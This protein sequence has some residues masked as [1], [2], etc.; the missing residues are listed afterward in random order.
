MH[1]LL[2]LSLLL[3]ASSAGTVTVDPADGAA[4]LAALRKAEPGDS[5][6]V[7]GAQGNLGI[8]YGIGPDGPWIV[9]VLTGSSAE[10]AGLKP[11]DRLLS[12]NGT[13]MEA[14]TLQEMRP[15]MGNARGQK[16]S[17][18]ILRDGQRRVIETER[19]DQT[20]SIS[21]DMD[22]ARAV[23]DSGVF[24]CRDVVRWIKP[25]AKRGDPEAMYRMARV[26]NE[27]CGEEK[28]PSEA[29]AWAK[30]AAGAGY[31]EAMTLAAALLKQK[32]ISG[33]PP[34]DFWA[35]K[36]C[37]AKQPLGCRLF[38][39]FETAAAL[40]DGDSAYELA[41]K[42][43]PSARPRWLK[44]AALLGNES[45]RKAFSAEFSTASCQGQGVSE[46]LA[47]LRAQARAG[48]GDAA[49]L[50]GWM[51]AAGDCVAKDHAEAL[52]WLLPQ[53]G[54]G[55]TAAMTGAGWLYVNGEGMERDPAKAVEWF[56]K[57][58]GRHDAAAQNNLALMYLY[59]EGTDKNEPEAMKWLRL[60]GF[61]NEYKSECDPYA[62]VRS[63]VALYNLAL[64]FEHGI[65]VEKSSEKAA[66][67]YKRAAGS[68]LWSQ[69]RVGEFRLSGGGGYALG[70]DDRAAAE[71]FRAAAKA[72]DPVAQY[73]MGEL[74]EQGRGVL[75]DARQAAVWYKR[76]AAFKGDPR[77]PRL[78]PYFAMRL[79]VRRL[80]PDS[81]AE[82]ELTA[83]KSRAARKAEEMR[84]ADAPASAQS[85]AV[86]IPRYKLPERPS[87]FAVVVGVERYAHL[88]RAD[89][90]ERDAQAVRDHLVALGYPPRNVA[91]LKGSDASRASIAKNLETWLPMNV[92]EDS[93]VFFYF[94]G[95]G[96]P[97]PRSGK[98]FLVP[99]DGDA[100]FLDDTAYPLTRV[101]EK[102]GALKARKVLVALDACFS[103][104]GERSALA[105]G[106][107]P[108]VVAAPPAQLP[109]KLAVLS[110]SLA[111]E[112]SGTDDE[113]G[114][115]LFTYYL[116]KGINGEAAAA[117]GSV[118]LQGLHG[119][120]LPI[121][122][123]EARR[124]NRLQTP[125]LEG[126]S[127]GVRLR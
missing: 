80:L 52:R 32:A 34:P 55:R 87:D 94:S 86:D 123:D 81:A 35:D 121:V 24:P 23:M 127:Q 79:D 90:A 5:V 49:L 1:I 99:A 33:E 37:K 71:E 8:R 44:R 68:D 19:G 15:P 47:I 57:A 62:Y 10:S 124:V 126:E 28:D 6:V 9:D 27:G 116:L 72:G 107:R 56:Q 119:Y 85:S 31:P 66:V 43:D 120:V 106:T 14:L 39:D 12:V 97:D 76:A 13:P 95:H 16:V 89:Y 109:P 48:G 21:S 91:L 2:S 93:T 67:C 61:D 108:L 46:D 25:L 53:A 114:H 104:A 17:I 7:R 22:K 4:A 105:K 82:A 103:G 69:V 117:D 102:L 45:A 59:G 118:T 112:I 54:K 122:Q 30:K 40:G 92:R 113:Q 41:Q 36:A 38:K 51:Y 96:S 77:G 3:S 18:E 111:N 58:A 115:G 60:A 83:L 20:F 50:L 75:K 63:P 98:A 101:Y 26:F 74:Y 73:R 84:S 29:F 11:K 70:K 88:P 42:A 110:A 125:Q 100:Q 64:L 78:E 65:Y